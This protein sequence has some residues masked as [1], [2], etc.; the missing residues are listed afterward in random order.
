MV[1]RGESGHGDQR[2]IFTK[3]NASHTTEFTSVLSSKTGIN[4]RWTQIVDLLVDSGRTPAEIRTQL[5]LKANDVKD[6]AQATSALPTL[7]QIRS[8]KRCRK[9]SSS[10]TWRLENNADL[11]NIFQ[12]S[13]ITTHEQFER[14]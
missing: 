1:R 7:K 8:R 13:K 5:I 9:L 6:K 14:A 3:E 4:P 12:C 11:L 10:V 2:I